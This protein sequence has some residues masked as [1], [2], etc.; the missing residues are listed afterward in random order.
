MTIR[1]NVLYWQKLGDKFTQFIVED[2][3]GYPDATTVITP[4]GI[5]SN[6]Q[7][8]GNIIYE[9]F[10]NMVR[11]LLRPNSVLNN[12][13][14]SNL[15]LDNTYMPGSTT[16]GLSIVNCNMRN[17][18]LAFSSH[19]TPFI[20]QTDLSFSQLN[21]SHITG[22]PNY[23]AVDRPTIYDSILTG[24][25]ISQSDISNARIVLNKTHSTTFEN[26]RLN[27]TN[28][29]INGQN[30]NLQNIEATNRTTI[31]L[32]GASA[33]SADIT[34]LRTSKDSTLQSDTSNLTR[35][36]QKPETNQKFEETQVIL[37]NVQ[38]ST[39]PTDLSKYR[40]IMPVGRNDRGATEMMISVNKNET[41][42]L[43]PNDSTNIAIPAKKEYDCIINTTNQGQKHTTLYGMMLPAV[44]EKGEYIDILI[45]P[46]PNKTTEKDKSFIGN[47][48]IPTSLQNQALYD[49]VRS[50]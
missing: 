45:K 8:N 33:H 12:V 30:A 41:W 13:G 25:N 44:Q 24:A 34:G 49:D 17:S 26:C 7:F 38:V 9:P 47:T 15:N 28:L 40:I 4:N 50:I 48:N 36:L 19:V 35:P 22:N 39:D 16:N 1:K 10:K 21:N 43:N 32:T 11:D 6:L 46:E 27:N 29:E 37:N 31:R 18:N 14:L 42:Q 2:E 5:L 3:N 20:R 23:G